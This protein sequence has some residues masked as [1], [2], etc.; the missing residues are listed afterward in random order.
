MNIYE[1]CLLSVRKFGGKVEDYIPIHSFID[2]SKYYYPT[3]KH[4]VLLHNTAGVQACVK[5]LG[6]EILP[7]G[8]LVRDVGFEHLKEDHSGKIPTL[9]DW[10]RG[11]TFKTRIVNYY[12]EFVSL[13]YDTDF[14]V[15]KGFSTNCE[16]LIQEVLEDIVFVDA[17][18]RIV[19]ATELKWLSD[20]K[21]TTNDIK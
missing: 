20:L 3:Y 13:I 17:W 12:S 15:E 7:S 2:S 9:L 18:T 4:R 16:N 11:V 21:N 1:H 8:V 14:G 5:H 10:F 19:D 6:C